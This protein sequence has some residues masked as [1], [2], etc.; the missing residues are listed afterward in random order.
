MVVSLSKPE[1]MSGDL[2][3]DRRLKD[4]LAA[5]L[6]T[7][8]PARDV[9]PNPGPNPGPKLSDPAAGVDGTP[10]PRERLLAISGGLISVAFVVAVAPFASHPMPHLNSLM[11]AYEGWSIL[12]ACLM[13]VMLFSQF[14]I[15]RSRGLFILACGCL[16]VGLAAFARLLVTPVDF[17]TT[18]FVGGGSQAS[19]W[20]FLFWTAGLPLTVIFYAMVPGAQGLASEF[21]DSRHRLTG[22]YYIA[23]GT[24]G[25]V[26]LV[27]GLWAIFG[28]GAVALPQV[29]TPTR[30]TPFAVKIATGVIAAS[31][32]ALV[33]M[34]RRKPR[35]MLDGWLILGL[36]GWLFQFILGG[37]LSK[38]PYDFAWYASLAYGTL[39][40]S[41]LAIVLAFENA[42]QH[43]RLFEMHSALLASNQALHHLSRHDALTGLPNR[44]YFDAHLA[45]QS[46]VMRR[47]KRCMAI[48]IF[49][50]DHFKSFNDRFGHQAGDDCL[51]HIAQALQS[52]CRRAGDLAARYGGEEFAFILP[53]TD[54]SSAMRLAQK[55][56][57]TVERLQ[58]PQG[59]E[60]SW[61]VVTISGGV[62]VYDG[63]HGLTTDDI[64]AAADEALFQAKSRGRNK[65]ISQSF[66]RPP[67]DIR[68]LHAV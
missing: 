56:R 36:V 11:P 52:C 41:A 21:D 68:R 44:R 61:P 59:P 16:F 14:A 49:D 33:V 50:V 63:H 45:Q 20:F 25:V 2:E 13:S 27:A 47:H 42:N 4:Q 48:V 22:R 3:S 54:L 51:A 31:I 67:S 17:A 66:E 18:N 8:D 10:G 9:L 1:N 40:S 64:I 43:R 28:S 37:L 62:A 30:F 57:E 23:A 53:E 55:A 26:A 35:T 15:V 58:V 65:I 7:T 60:S 19:T 38:H 29:S 34:F 39:G 5:S 24:L 12:S 46:G 6:R 32:L